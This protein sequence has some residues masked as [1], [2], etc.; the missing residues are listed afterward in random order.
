MELEHAADVHSGRYWV[1]DLD[2]PRVRWNLGLGDVKDEHERGGNLVIG[3]SGDRLHDRKRG[4]LYEFQRWR[5]RRFRTQ[6]H[7][8]LPGN[9]D[10]ECDKFTCWTELRQHGGDVL[11][12]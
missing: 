11:E 8:E 12:Q 1:T 9:R 7:F 4:L 2:R 6:P 5:R 10:G 3:S